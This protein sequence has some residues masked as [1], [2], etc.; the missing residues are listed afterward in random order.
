[1]QRIDPASRGQTLET[2]IA[3]LVNNARVAAQ[4]AK[5]YSALNSN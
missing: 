3:L 4:I 2:N 1:M 5:P